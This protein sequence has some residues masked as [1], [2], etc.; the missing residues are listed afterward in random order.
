MTPTT[1]TTRI[2][3]E[4]ESGGRF[5]VAGERGA[6]ECRTSLGGMPILIDYHSP[7]PWFPG[8][9]PSACDVIAGDCYPEAGANVIGLRSAWLAAGGDDEVIWRALEARYEAWEAEDR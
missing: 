4:D 5:I 8:D 2:H 9:E 1:G 3:R 6:V 7:R